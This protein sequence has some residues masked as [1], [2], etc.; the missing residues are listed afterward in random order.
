MAAPMPCFCARMAAWYGK[1]S[2]TDYRYHVWNQ[3]WK[4]S[5]DENTGGITNNIRAVLKH[6]V[7]L[8]TLLFALVPGPSLGAEIRVATASNFRDAMAALANRFEQQSE[9]TVIPIYG[10]TG[11]H[12]A[13]IL[14]G[15]PYDIFF[16]A[17]SAHPEL[18]EQE[19]MGVPGSRFTYAVGNL[20][21][22]SPK[23]N[24]VDAAGAILGQ[25]DFR[26]LAIANPRLAPYG[27]AAMQTLQ[28]LGLWDKL[29]KRLVRGENMGHA[30]QYVNSG[31][32]ELGFIAWSQLKRGNKTVAGSFWL[33][34]PELYD[35]IIQQAVLL[36]DNQATRSFMT[37]AR[38]MEAR[39][40][41]RQLGYGLP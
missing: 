34:P 30:F 31:N 22:W 28:A 14:N 12:Y 32:A 36:T 10:S 9:H 4:L 11:K 21:L 38:S 26:H 6:S 15:A 33:V 35:P 24:Y 41:I 1:A 20:T 13:Q 16:A 7:L 39:E 27:R 19:G 5:H 17:D 29:G 40:I 25:G 2:E 23:K 37:Y 8:L 18:L 3:S